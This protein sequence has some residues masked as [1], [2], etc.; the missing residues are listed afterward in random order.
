MPELIQTINQ[1]ERQKRD[2]LIESNQ[3]SVNTRDNTTYLNVPGKIGESYVLN[4]TA[5][6]QLATR[7][8]IPYR[9]AEKL[10]MEE[11]RLLD[12]NLNTLFRRSNEKR[13]IR[14]LGPQCRAVL[15]PNYRILDNYAFLGTVLPMLAQMPDAKLNE[16]YLTETHLHISLVF[17]SAQGYVKPGDP[18][19]YGIM[20]ANSEVGMGSLSVWSFIHR[21]V[22]SNGLVVTEADGPSVRRVHIGKRMED[23]TKLPSDREVWLEYGDVVR[24]TADNKRLPQILHRLQLAAQSPV[25]GAPEDAV[26]KLAKKFQLT[27]DEGERVLS[28]Y[29]AG[30][31]LS[32]WG[33]V[34]AITEA[35]KDAESVQRRVE[36]QTIGGR[37]LP[38][39]RLPMLPMA[40]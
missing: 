7:L 32:T 40:A 19:R 34:N 2:H 27:K 25:M 35:A 20:L 10:R 6:A 12:Q 22:C 4:D 11:P 8:E 13:L 5:R 23:L 24:A 36:M 3:L 29:I 37:L 14:T 28:R 31:D 21:L 9:Y 33:L 1:Q 38:E 30:N 39:S 16:A 26:E 18:V 17:Q 15:S